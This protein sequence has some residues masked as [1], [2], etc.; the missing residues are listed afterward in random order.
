MKIKLFT[1]V[2]TLLCAGYV[3]AT[4]TQTPIAV[5]S[6]QQQIE[7]YD[8]DG[9]THYIDKIVPGH[10]WRNLYPN[11]KTA[12]KGHAYFIAAGE[13]RTFNYYT[14]GR[15]KMWFNYQFSP[16]SPEVFY[17]IV[18]TETDEIVQQGRTTVARMVASNKYY[19]GGQEFYEL[20]VQF[21]VN[22]LPETRMQPYIYV[23]YE[24]PRFKP[25]TT[26]GYTRDWP[27]AMY[28]YSAFDVLKGHKLR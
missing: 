19:D 25:H 15:E 8:F 18:N 27:Q 16:D 28:R 14:M 12:N 22:Y 2:M 4:E 6:E 17:Q 1:A 23:R 24:T 9:R 11:W 5:E 10:D 21:D 26:R 3:G 20:E 13:K 7:R